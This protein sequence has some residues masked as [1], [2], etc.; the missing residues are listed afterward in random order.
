MGWAWSQDPAPVFSVVAAAYHLVLGN[1]HHHQDIHL[2]LVPFLAVVAYQA[3]VVPF[4]VEEAYLVPYQAV[5]DPFQVEVASLIP[6]LVVEAFLVP[7][8]AEVAYQSSYEAGV[9]FPYQVVEDPC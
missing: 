9:A 4:Q 7:F 8:L 6:F 3:A 2:D 5:V 1:H